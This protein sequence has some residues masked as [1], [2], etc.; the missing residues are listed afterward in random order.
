MDSIPGS[1]KLPW[2]RKRQPSPVT[3]SSLENLTDRGVG[4]ATVH[5]VR[6]SWT[7]Q[8]STLAD[9]FQPGHMVTKVRAGGNAASPRPAQAQLTLEPP[10]GR[11]G[12]SWE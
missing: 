1:L 7:E 2:R 3:L 6:R 11:L 4:W 9:C 12:W 5:V 8:A 10:A